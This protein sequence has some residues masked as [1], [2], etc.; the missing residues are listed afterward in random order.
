[1]LLDL[2]I[3]TIKKNMY[4]LMFLLVFPDLDIMITL[5]IVLVIVIFSCDLL[6]ATPRRNETIVVLKS[7]GKTKWS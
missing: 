1:M 7:I 3:M 4:F 2:D 6:V 5:F